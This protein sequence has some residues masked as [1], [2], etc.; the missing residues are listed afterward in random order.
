MYME[1]VLSIPIPKEIKVRLLKDMKMI[2]ET[3]EFVEIPGGPRSYKPRCS[4][5]RGFIY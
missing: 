3:A 5:I 2:E 4:K 1:E